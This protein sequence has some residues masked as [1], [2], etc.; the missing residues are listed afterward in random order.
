MP[1]RPPYIANYTRIGFFKTVIPVTF[2]GYFSARWVFLAFNFQ[3]PDSRSRIPNPG[4]RMP[5]PRCQTLKSAGSQIL[6]SRFRNR[7]DPGFWITDP[8]IP[9]SRF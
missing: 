3:T 6:D 5:D 9:D 8:G 1:A 4:S 2:F 7:P